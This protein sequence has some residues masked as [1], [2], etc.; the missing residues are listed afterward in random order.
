MLDVDLAYQRY[1]TQMEQEETEE[2]Y[3]MDYNEFYDKYLDWNEGL[4]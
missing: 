2:Q 4:R 3:I 1:L